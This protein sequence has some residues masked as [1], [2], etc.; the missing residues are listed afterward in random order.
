VVVAEGAIDAA[1]EVGE[2]AG[3][4]H[5]GTQPGEDAARVVVAAVNAGLVEGRGALQEVG[6]A[7]DQRHPLAP[8][9]QGE[10]QRA[11]EESAAD[12]HGAGTRVSHGSAPHPR[13][14]AWRSVRNR[15]KTGRGG[16]D[17]GRTRTRG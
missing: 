5:P 14:L 2:E 17:P 6:L 8:F 10:R 11:A 1:G 12:D 9:T 16:R 13:T 3:A 15:R 4:V 7:L